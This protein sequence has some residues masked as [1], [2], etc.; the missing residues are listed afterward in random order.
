MN[1]VRYA[2]AFYVK[3]AN[4]KRFKQESID[5]PNKISLIQNLISGKHEKIQK[6]LSY[7]ELHLFTISLFSSSRYSQM[8]KYKREMF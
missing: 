3:A 1:K 2:Y 4:K 5:L 7:K 6:S 8:P